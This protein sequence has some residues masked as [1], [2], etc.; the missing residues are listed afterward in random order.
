[1]TIKCLGIRREDKSKWERRV[2][3][4][5]EQVA[6]LISET[7]IKVFIQPSQ[8]RAFSDQAYRDAG[9]VVQEDLS[10]CDLVIAVKEIPTALLRPKTSYLY[11]SH[12]IKGQSYNM[13][14]LQRLLDLESNLL[15]YEPIQDGQGRRL[16]FFGKYAGLAGM[17]D[18]LWTL[19]Q[20]LKKE[21]FDT[22][23]EDLKPAF[24]YQDLAQA[25]AAVQSVGEALKAQSLPEQ[26]T[27]MAF[28]FLGYGN[29]SQ[30]A[31]E[32]FDLLPHQ[33]LCPDDLLDAAKRE[34]GQLIK[35]VYK[36]KDLAERKDGTP[37]VLEDY[38]QQPELFQ[39]CF[40]LH[41]PLLTVII[42]G[43]YWEPRYPRF[44]PNDLVAKARRESK[45]HLRVVGDI[46][47]D[48]GGTIEC[49]VKATTQD[50]PTFTYLPESSEVRD[51]IHVDGLT[52]MAVD[53]LPCELPVDASRT[54]GS[55]LLPLLPALV[56]AD[57]EAS[58]EAL[59]LPPSLKRAVITYQGELT[60]NYRYLED[61]L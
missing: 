39:S 33:V 29:V 7:Q 23:F 19:G 8:I 49:T 10:E 60:P 54:F 40:A 18:T 1:M 11:F 48:I 20:R 30:G 25:K 56:D 36:E 51:G 44:L 5:P 4:A 42:T 53:N 12:T 26:L 21:G 13:D 59:N 17:L 14:M 43:I 61:F 32:M 37:F 22:P 47:C 28:G 35:V 2:P 52:V 50:E 41:A 46:T 31:Q 9:A 16:V 57:F 3:L 6:Q 38:Y 27:P 34:N 55:M 45:S 24:G 15:D 58:F